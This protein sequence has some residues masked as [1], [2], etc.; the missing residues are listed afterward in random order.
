[1]T[2]E[3]I[4]RQLKE[5]GVYLQMFEV[6]FKPQAYEKPPLVIESLNEEV[7]EIY[8]KEG[9]RGLT[10]I[11]GIGKGIADKIQE[12]LKTGRIK[13]RSTQAASAV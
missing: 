9:K 4:A 2:N 12:L 11:P 6:P 7:S 10:K 8:K 1:M 3:L 5:L 13:G